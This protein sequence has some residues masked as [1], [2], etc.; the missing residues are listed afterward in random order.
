MDPNN[1]EYGAIKQNLQQ[2]GEFIKNSRKHLDAEDQRRAEQENPDAPPLY[3]GVPA[4]LMLAAQDAST[5]AAIA[6]ENLG[7]AKLAADVRRTEAE[8]DMAIQSHRQKMAANDVEL[9]LK[10]RQ[11]NAPKAAPKAKKR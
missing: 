11:A 1:P 3:G 8:T 5:R 6:K 9:A 10:V 4:G 2:L 7:A